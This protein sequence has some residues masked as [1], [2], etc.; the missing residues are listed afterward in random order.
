MFEHMVIL[1]QLGNTPLL[2]AQTL[3]VQTLS[4]RPLLGQVGVPADPSTAEQAALVFSG[5]Q[6]LVALVSGLLLAFAMQLL[7]TNLSVA[8]GI[9][10]IGKSSGH[11]DDHSD[12]HSS[13]S[14][15]STIRKIGF[16]VGLWTLISVSVSLFIACYLAVQLSLLHT[17]V[18]LGAIVGLV[19]WAAYFTLLVWFSSSTVGSLIGSVVN[20]ATSGFQAIVGTAAAALGGKAV[21]DQIVSTAEAAAAAVRREFTVDVNPT[22]VRDTIEDYIDKIRPAQLD[23]SNI[24]REFE[25]ILSD[26]EVRSMVGPEGLNVDRQ[27][28]VDLVSSRTDLSKMEVD[29]IAE[30]LERVWK[31]TLGQQQKPDQ[32]T[33]LL[34]YLRSTQEGQ[35]NTQ[36]VSSK[37]DQLVAEMKNTR[38][39]QG[40]QQSSSRWQTIQSNVMPLIGLVMGRSD[41]SDLSVEKILGQLKS[42][43]T[44]LGTQA[45]KV[46]SQV[47]DQQYSTVRADVE[48]YLLNAYF[49]QMNTD[50]I[51]REFHDVLYDPGANPRIVRQQLERLSRADF[52]NLLTS[53]GMFTQAKIQDIANQLDGIRREVILTARAAEERQAALDLRQM[54]ETY[55][56]LT[57]VDH[58]NSNE[59]DRAFG[60]LLQDS[61]VDHETLTLRLAAYDRSTLRGLLSQRQDLSPEQMELL[62]NQLEQTRD[63][64]LF[65]SQSL[66]DQAKQRTEATWEKLQSYLRSTGKDELNPEAIKNE[67]Q[68]LL[69][70]PQ[71][72]FSALQARASRFDH[73]T[74]VQLLS[75]RQDL[76]EDQVNSVLNQVEDTWHRVR[77]APQELTGAAKE[78]YDKVT[79]GLAD[80]LR[81]TGKEELNPEGIKQ[82]LNVLFND[83]QAGLYALRNRLS[84][85]DRDTLVKLLSQRQDLSEEQVN[86]IIDQVQENIRSIVGVPRR[87]AKRT[88]QRVL[89]FESAI[90]D[91]LR[92]TN[93]EELDPEGIKRDLQ[94][95]A[96]DPRL[97]LGNLRD[98]LSR[99][100][101]STVTSL[102]SQRE[103]ISPEE[104]NRIVAQ[105][106]S[107]R[108]RFL[109]QLQEVQYRIQ[110]A[111]DSI[112]A[113]IRSYLNGLERPELNYDGI[114]QDLRTVLDDPQ[115][116]FDA[117]RS[118]LG[119]FDRGT[120]V[121]LL[122]SRKDISEADAN[123]II[124]QIE[125]ARNSVLQRAER[126]QIEAQ[127]RLEE[128]KHQAQKQAEETRKAAATAAWW[129][130]AT[131]FISAIAAAVGGAIA[132][133]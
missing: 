71:A 53:R 124:D 74:L 14:I 4:V 85:V 81:K 87:L 68:L 76:S 118:R 115:A 43:Q 54:V 17:A 108:D 89:N 103:D 45:E 109:L 123:R 55:L 36:E 95:L 30:Q 3:L 82:D 47:S 98:R 75:Q 116:G 86:Q 99:F 73:D 117:L 90:E 78:Q 97:G 10:F 125:G 6:F 19:I 31:Q 100:D 2:S 84:Q 15:G 26:P 24:R 66:S 44:T 114:R 60:A 63:R 112:F 80:Y 94:L 40:D 107:V 58:F 1:E 52:V 69:H 38:S 59:I 91:Y 20:T 13:G 79:T 96:N 93:K 57:T 23:F 127:K 130:F 56:T 122:S 8:L 101:R 61:D 42:A 22:R 46:V 16:G 49:W 104:A 5:P 70:D 129:L 106:E 28:F 132:V 9:S 67:L 133:G 62:L 50:T 110:G 37:L 41:L 29:R 25:S 102:L 126:I 35:L 120:L 111:I 131:A 12:D 33:Q 128:L 88:Q 48:N 121:A 113:R 119:Q 51:D 65:E 11:H 64:V 21:N 7:L 92:N 72:G 83:P 32:M 27:K 39:P 105:I 18:G 34:E 77:H